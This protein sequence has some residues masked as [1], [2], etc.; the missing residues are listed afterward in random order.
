MATVEQ[1]LQQWAQEERKNLAMTEQESVR[2][3]N[4]I[5]MHMDEFVVKEAQPVV[6]TSVS[7]WAFWMRWSLV[8]AMAAVFMMMAVLHEGNGNVG[9]PTVIPANPAATVVATAPMVTVAPEEVVLEATTIRA[10]S[11]RGSSTRHIFASRG[12]S[13]FVAWGTSVYGPGEN[14]VTVSQTNSKNPWASSVFS[15]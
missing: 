2:I 15:D 8:P 7:R 5:E 1:L 13:V 12:Q 10:P 6:S 14:V 3:W 4:R 9:E 11:V